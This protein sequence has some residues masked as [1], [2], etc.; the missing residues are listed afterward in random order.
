[1]NKKMLFGLVA[2]VTLLM[3]SH[4]VVI[5]AETIVSTPSVDYGKNII[6]N[7][8]VYTILKENGKKVK[9]PYT[10]E[11]AFL[12]YSFNKWSNV[13]SASFE[14]TNLPTGSFIPPR[15]GTIMC[16]DRWPDQGTCYLVTDSKKAG[17]TNENA[18][19]SGG[20]SYQWALYGDVSFLQSATHIENGSEMRRA[21]SI[22]SWN[23]VIYLITNAGIKEIPNTEILESWGYWPQEALIANSSDWKFAKA[24]TMTKRNSYEIRP[25][26]GKTKEIQ[27]LNELKIV[28]SS[29]PTA[30]AGQPYSQSLKASGGTKPYR[31]STEDTNYPSGCCVL[32][33]SGQSGG[34]SDYYGMYEPV[35]FNTQTSDFVLSNHIGTYYWTFV[36]TDA[37]G[38]QARKTLNLKIIQ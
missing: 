11:G 2:V 30:I 26:L 17:F 35:V 4:P 36:V 25:D 18:F 28:T 37:N 3:T 19:Y 32:G 23:N 6:V 38:K 33:L 16:S 31:W 34:S 1:M 15:D 14:E 12:S 21:G 29:L 10:S 27:D 9:R 8:T 13:V 24:G 20:Y 7:G 5:S 22:L